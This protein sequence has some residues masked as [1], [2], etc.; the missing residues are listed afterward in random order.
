MEMRKKRAGGRVRAWMFFVGSLLSAWVVEAQPQPEQSEENLEIPVPARPGDR[1]APPLVPAEPQEGAEPEAPGEEE[2][3]RVRIPQ[4]AATVM[5][6]PVDD[7]TPGVDA[8]Y[9][10]G[11]SF[12][13]NDGRF[14]MTM[15][16]R[17]QPRLTVSDRDDRDTDI[18]FAVRRARLV[19]LGNLGSHHV[20]YYVQLSFAPGDLEPDQNIVLRDAVMTWSKWRDLNIRVGQTKVPFNRERV[21]SSSALQLVD[22][23]IVN[24][25]LNLDRDIGIHF[26]SNDLFGL[27]ERLGYQISIT[28]GQ[29]RNRANV[30]AGLL[31]VARIQVQPLGRFELS[32]A[33]SEADLSRSPT[34]R[35]SIG[36]GG[37]YNHRSERE[38]STLGAFF[39]ESSFD[40]IHGEVDLIY[41]QS[42][43]SLQSEFLIRQ[44][45]ED[46]KTVVIDGEAVTDISRSGFGYFVQAGYMFPRRYEIAARWS[47]LRPTHWVDT[48]L[49]TRREMTVG[50]S[51]YVLD[52]NLKVQADYG[53]LF[54][55]AFED[56][57]HLARI[58][59]QFFF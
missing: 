1:P 59:S 46:A 15:R 43:F 9:G 10:R 19:F 40:Q 55:Q 32:D 3:L 4:Q 30:G 50:L 39:A 57:Q 54:G 47:E 13:S 18:D 42:G 45:T 7:V 29:G 34:P 14:S 21:I 2:A 20:Q 12:A 33:Y 25:E 37:G 58:Q 35:L 5:Y 31:Y 23:S 49:T 16:G 51:K 11:V 38:L 56:R 26:F 53:Y 22:R 36:V 28:N 6:V 8:E 52:H 48:E 44:A 24:A 27:G 17:I 41:K